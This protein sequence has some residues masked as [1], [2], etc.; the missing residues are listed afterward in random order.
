MVGNEY[1]ELNKTFFQAM[2]EKGQRRKKRRGCETYFCHCFAC[3]NARLPR[4]G[5]PVVLVGIN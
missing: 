4:A 3:V 2:M 5:T 1:D